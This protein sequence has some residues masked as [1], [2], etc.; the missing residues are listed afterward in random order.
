MVH[1]NH[2]KLVIKKSLCIL[3]CVGVIKFNISFIELALYHLNCAF[4][5][6]IEL[7]W[8]I[9]IYAW[10]FSRSTG[11]LYFIFISII[12]NQLKNYCNFTK[13]KQKKTHTIRW[14][15]RK[16]LTRRWSTINWG[17]STNIILIINHLCVY[18]VTT[19]S[20]VQLIVY[21][22]SSAHTIQIHS[23]L[24]GILCKISAINSNVFHFLSILSK[25]WVQWKSLLIQCIIIKII[26]I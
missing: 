26:I 21:W 8:S 11:D 23:T 10:L 14:E 4:S 22:R 19:H 17:D 5:I 25:N 12:C 15:Q 2:K 7:H 24:I 13:P 1:N 18:K 20:N 9:Y 16:Q 3:K 6:S